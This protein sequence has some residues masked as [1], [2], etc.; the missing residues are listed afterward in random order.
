MTDPGQHPCNIVPSSSGNDDQKHLRRPTSA[1]E[2]IEEAR[3]RKAFFTV[4][5]LHLQQSTD[6]Q[7]QQIIPTFSAPDRYWVEFEHWYEQ[8][9]ARRILRKMRSVR[10]RSSARQKQR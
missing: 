8:R 10:A 9:Q 7:I 2:L 6:P 4:L 3:T 1:Q 5:V